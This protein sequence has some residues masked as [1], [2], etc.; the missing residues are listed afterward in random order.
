MSEIFTK[1]VTYLQTSSEQVKP[2][3]KEM[4]V[5]TKEVTKTATFRELSRTEAS[6]H[7]LQFELIGATINSKTEDGNVVLNWASLYDITVKSIN[8]LLVITPEFTENDK[9]RFLN[10]SKALINFGTWFL[11]EKLTPF[12]SQLMSS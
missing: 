2:G 7:K 4:E 10:D 8:T 11:G 3:S 1:E 12:F 5:V 9:K 6:Q